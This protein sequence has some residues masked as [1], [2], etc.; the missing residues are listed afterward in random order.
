MPAMRFI[1]SA[2]PLLAF[3]AAAPAFAEDA[4]TTSVKTETVKESTSPEMYEAYLDKYPAGEFAS[5]A[6]TKLAELTPAMDK[7]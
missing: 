5:L 3:L 7:P 4:K 2:L 1:T 6:R